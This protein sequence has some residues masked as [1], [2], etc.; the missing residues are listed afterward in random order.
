MVDAMIISATRRIDR[1]VDFL[2]QNRLPFVA[3]G[4]T[5]SSTDHAWV[6]LDFEGVA[7]S[8]IDRLVASG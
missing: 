2:K 4:R 5:A 3:L 8:A 7:K 6:D 1:R